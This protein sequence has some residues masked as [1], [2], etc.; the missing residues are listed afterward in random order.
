MK[1][2]HYLAHV[3]SATPMMEVD[4]TNLSAHRTKIALYFFRVMF[5]V[6]DVPSKKDLKLLGQLLGRVSVRIEKFPVMRTLQVES[7]PVLPRSSTAI[8]VDDEGDGKIF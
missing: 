4:E 7:H 6:L 3:V 8:R 5:P 2:P 1:H